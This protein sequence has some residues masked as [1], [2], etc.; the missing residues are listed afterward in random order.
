MS[1]IITRVVNKQLHILQSQTLLVHRQVPV[2]PSLTNRVNAREA[3][4]WG[5]DA[6]IGQH[7]ALVCVRQ[8]RD[9]ASRKSTLAHHVHVSNGLADSGQSTLERD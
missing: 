2:P 9:V 7:R 3:T 4:R 6:R 1:S 5:W 8:Q